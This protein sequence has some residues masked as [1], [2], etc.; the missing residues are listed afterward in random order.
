MFFFYLLIVVI[1]VL[2]FVFFSRSF[3]FAAE[4]KKERRDFIDRSKQIRTGMSKSEVIKI[5]GNTYSHSYLQN[6]IEKLE[7]TKRKGGCGVAFC[8]IFTY[9]KPIVHSIC[10]VFQDDIVI[11]VYA[12][13]MV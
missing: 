13:N 8:G 4:I 9:D 11:E 12:N 1:L 7:W 5:M 3:Y 2:I 6:N 10:V